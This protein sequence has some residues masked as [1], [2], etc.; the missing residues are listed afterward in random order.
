MF[1]TMITTGHL[2]KKLLLP[3][4]MRLIDFGWSVAIS[5][6]NIVVGAVDDEGINGQPEAGS[7]YVFFNSITSNWEQ[8]AK[9]W[10][11]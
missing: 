3:M 9:L 5:G 8:T 2:I 11:L 1:I 4:V 7:A 6:Q 10:A